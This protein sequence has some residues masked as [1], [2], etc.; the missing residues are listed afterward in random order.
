MIQ[1]SFTTQAEK[2]TTYDRCNAPIVNGR[3]GKRVSD[4]CAFEQ[5]SRKNMD[6]WTLNYKNTNVF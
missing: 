2:I 1:S 5:A 6:A 3:N 4:R